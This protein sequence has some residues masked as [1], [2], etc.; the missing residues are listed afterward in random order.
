[1]K[2]MTRDHQ[3]CLIYMEKGSL[4]DPSLELDEN[5]EVTI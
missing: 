2:T 3:G 4:S 1:M 5:K